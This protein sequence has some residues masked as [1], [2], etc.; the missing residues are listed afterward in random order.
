MVDDRMRIYCA[1]CFRSKVGK[2]KAEWFYDFLD[3]LRS[4][5]MN[6]LGR[7]AVHHDLSGDYHTHRV[8]LQNPEPKTNLNGKRY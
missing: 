3:S 8:L 6:E 5:E 7:K 2:I 1:D 4:L